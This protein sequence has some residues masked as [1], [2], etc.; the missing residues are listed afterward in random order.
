MSGLSA[1]SFAGSPI[2]LDREPVDE[3]S[4]S[5]RGEL[6]TRTSPGY[7]QARS[8]WNA[9]IDRRPALIAR[10]TDAD[11]VQ[12]AVRFVRDHDL[13]VAVRGG[14]HNIAGTAV[15]DGGMVIDLSRMKDV[16]V[17]ADARRATVGPGATLGDFDGEA[18]RHGLATP[19]G[20]NSTTG[21][22]GLTL[23]GG[24]GWLTRK[25]GMTVD[26]LRSAEI[27]TMDGAIRRASPEEHPDL[28]WALRGGG[29]N[30]GVVTAF[31][32]D[33]HPVGPDVWSGVV[34]YRA[35]D[36]PAALRQWRDFAE[37]AEEETAVWAILRP[38]PP[39]PFLPEESHGDDVLVLA[40]FHAGDPAE[41]ERAT[42]PVRSFGVPLG[43]HM[44]PQPYVEFQKAFDPLLTPG[45]RN[46]WKTHDFSHLSDATLDDAVTLA[47]EC[48]SPHCEVFFGQ[49]GGAMERVAPDATAYAGR[50]ARYVMNVH[51]RWES[52]D[53]DEAGVG[54]TRRVYR[55]MEPRATG[56][57]YVN[58][59]TEEE[60]DRVRWAYGVNYER[61]ARIKA[62]Y[63]PRN[64]LRTNMNIRPAVVA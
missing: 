36:A 32:F 3:L 30:F 43:E 4:A 26:N 6:L 38:A 7:E 56:G 8:V 44:G 13:L 19:L 59:L 24:F 53:E 60:D 52:P 16:R 54:W 55:A 14:G 58:F 47:A 42:A 10:C 2:R 57:A 45:A 62:E 46:Y 64:R 22:A 20:I 39:L 1:R 17:E 40:A 23:G 25:H 31:E 15:C 5:I 33:L 48:P 21:V 49:L 63:D 27:V 37:E 18:Q 61:L 28:F 12:E 29:G 41:G 34:V 35:E 9:M 51:G 50:D 11:D